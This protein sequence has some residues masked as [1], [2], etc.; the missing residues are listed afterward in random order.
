MVDESENPAHTPLYLGVNPADA[1]CERHGEMIRQGPTVV[2]RDGH[3]YATREGVFLFACPEC[4]VDLLVTVGEPNAGSDRAIAF[5]WDRQLER[6]WD[7]LEASF[8]D[9]G[10]GHLETRKGAI[11]LADGWDGRVDV[12]GRATLAEA[13]EDE[14]DRR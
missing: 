6:D 3:V 10:T 11:V 2:G 7:A 13:I 1:V 5:V 4:C 8:I 12:S 9:L 14:H